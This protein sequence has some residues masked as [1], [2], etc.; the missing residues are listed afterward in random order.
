MSFSAAIRSVLSKYAAFSGRA[1]RSEYWWWALAYSVAY[2]VAGALD[3]AAGSS[4][5]FVALIALPLFLPTLAVGVRR[6][7]DT[8]RSGWWMLASFVPI[9]G[10]VLLLVFLCSESGTPN[11]YGDNPK[12]PTQPGSG[13]AV[14]APRP[15]DGRPR[16]C[17][18][19]TCPSRGT[20]VISWGCPECGSP[21]QLAVDC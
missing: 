7:H 11:R 16:V 18:T 2:L 17:V 6:L 3:S 15:P 8:G 14:V 5:A 19:S 10:L 12:S 20:H 13:A 21:T 9:L 4:P 1:R